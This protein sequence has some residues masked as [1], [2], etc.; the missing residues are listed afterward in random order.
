MG[1][2]GMEVE[3]SKFT[4]FI[5]F[6]TTNTYIM[7]IMSDKTIEKAVTQLNIKAARS[8]FE[9]YVQQTNEN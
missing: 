8:Q 7:I 2:Q 4:A 6:F 3:N 5:D 1:F 9:E